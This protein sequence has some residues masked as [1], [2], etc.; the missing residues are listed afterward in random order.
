[1]NSSM[2][3]V[4]GDAVVEPFESAVYE[5]RQCFPAVLL[6]AAVIIVTV[7]TIKKNKKK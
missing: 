4:Y 1:M 5:L 6:I 3:V 2:W 7:I